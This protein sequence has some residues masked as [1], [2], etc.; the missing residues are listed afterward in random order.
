[1]SPQL[2]CDDTCQIWTW[3]WKLTYVMTE[4][5]IGEN[6]GTE[7]IGLVIPT[8]GPR[9]G[10]RQ[11]CLGL[12]GMWRYSA[13]TLICTS[14][15]LSRQGFNQRWKMLNT[16]RI[17]KLHKE[18]IEASFKYFVITIVNCNIHSSLNQSFK[19]RVHAHGYLLTQF[20][21]IY[22]H[23]RFHWH[24]IQCGVVIKRSTVSQILTTDTP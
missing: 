23:I 6:N 4:L 12:D 16:Q 24:S 3:L 21:G 13:V 7:E 14:I 22:N 18:Y 20:Q 11:I 5:K 1:M 17:P 8:P 2:S 15:S 9:Q 19:Y 10:S